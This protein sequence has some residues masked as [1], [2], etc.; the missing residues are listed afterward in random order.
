MENERENLM[1]RL[2]EASFAIDE[3]K[4]FLDNNPTDQKALDYYERYKKLRHSLVEEYTNR[5]GPL[6]ADNVNVTNEWTWATTPWPW[7]M[8]D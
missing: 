1:K 4:L 6:T 7:E 5:F 2:F 8:E 3:V